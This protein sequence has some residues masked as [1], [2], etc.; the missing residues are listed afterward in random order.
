MESYLN[1]R[2]KQFGGEFK[3]QHSQTMERAINK[4]SMNVLICSTSPH[5][6]ADL[7]LCF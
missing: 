7:V 4:I 5:S 2:S 6:C 3:G 1:N